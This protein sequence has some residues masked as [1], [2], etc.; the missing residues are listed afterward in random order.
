MI[1]VAIVEDSEKDQELLLSL[2]QEWSNT[3]DDNVKC[4]VFCD[5]VNFLE[6]G[7]TD[8][9]IIFMD[10]RMPHMSGMTAAE[11]LR[12]VNSCS[13]L[14]FLTSLAGYAIRG[15]SV[16]A[17]DYII[18]PIKKE[19]FTKVFERAVL[20]MRQQKKHITIS[21]KDRTVKVGADEISYIES[22]DHDKVFHVGAEVYRVC[23]D[24]EKL[25][26]D[27]PAN[28]VRCHR[29]YII[30]LK[31]VEEVGKDYVKLFGEAAHIPVSRNRRDELL[32]AITK[33]Y[34][35]NM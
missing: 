31:S 2:I 16:D 34:A 18:K 21:A 29:S 12:Q 1:R 23:D 25:L 35:R 3:H 20:R 9:D 33:Y 11:K 15:Y 17:M 30:N 24:M 14:I 19:S 22:L 26:G 13:I 28:F 7:T 32:E 27:L 5:A 4:D 8:F 6:T 10:I